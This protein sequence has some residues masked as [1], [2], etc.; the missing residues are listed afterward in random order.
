MSN[1][2]NNSIHDFDFSLICEYFSS[3]KRQGP[4]S[5]ASTHEAITAIPNI[6][7]NFIIADIGCGTGSSAIQ[8]AKETQASVVAIDL[9]HD[10]LNK[11]KLNAELAGVSHK[12]S[13]L[14]ADMTQLSL[15][16]ESFDLIWSEGA[17]YNIGF[18]NG[19]QEWNSFIRKNGYIAV[20]DS[21]WLTDYRPAEIES[22]WLDAYPE[23][24]TLDNNI[25]KMEQAG[26]RMIKTAVL[27]NDCWTKNFYEPQENAQNV[28]LERHHDDFTA[29]ELVKNQRHEAELFAKYNSYYGY[30]WYIGQKI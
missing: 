12:V 3:I 22:F 11:V 28:F 17:I 27:P 15:E 24:D 19:L 29:N 18:K 6:N 26:Y 25:T 14:Q 5:E 21:T 20:T 13:T 4:G 9:F 8:L 7:S 2:E 16:K 10:F 30:V 23:I 1:Q